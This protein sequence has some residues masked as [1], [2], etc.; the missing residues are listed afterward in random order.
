MTSRGKIILGDCLEIMRGFADNQFDLVLTDPPY[1]ITASV[2]DTAVDFMRDA[3]RVAKG[4][5]VT[6]S[7]P[8][9]SELVSAYREHFK[10]EWIWV[11]NRGSNFATLKYQPMKEHESILVFGKPDYYPIM[12]ERTGGGGDRI[13]Y[14]FNPSNTG[15]RDGLGKMELKYTNNQGELRHPSS[16]QKFN[17]EVGL[18]PTQKPVKLMSYLIRT[19]TNEGDTILDPFAGSGSTLVAAQQLNRNYVGIEINPEYAKIAE[20]RLKQGALL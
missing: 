4:A 2:W 3:L 7:Q 9:T 5:V 14:D 19:Y 1:G 17:T 18:H 16:V 10:Y 12:Q 13:K 20:D 8:Y 11:K 15:K 6:A